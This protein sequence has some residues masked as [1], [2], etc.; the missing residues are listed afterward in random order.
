[1]PE[2]P[3]CAIYT[4]KSTSEGLDQEFNTLHAQRE[5]CER[6]IQAKAHEGWQILPDQYDDG[7]FTGANIERPAFQHLLADIDAG[8]IDLVIVYKVDR[9]SR[10]LLDFAQVMDRFNRAGV[11]FVSVTQNFSTADA[12]GRLTLNMLMSFAEFEREMIAE[13]TR[14]KIA[15]SRRKGIW[16]GGPVPLGYDVIDKKL[17]VNPVETPMVREIFELYVE[18]RSARTVARILNERGRTTKHHRAKNGNARGGGE[19]AKNSVLRVVCNPILAGY[20]PYRDE[21]HDGEHEAVIATDLFARVQT[22]LETRQK[23]RSKGVRNPAYILRGVLYCGCGG[24]CTPASARS[25]GKEYRYYRCVTRNR[26]GNEACTARPLPADAIE[27]F[28]IDRILEE[29]SSPGLAREVEVELLARIEGLRKTHQ[30]HIKVL[31]PRIKGL[32]VQGRRLAEQSGESE[33]AARQL[34]EDRI[35][36]IGRELDE[37]QKQVVDAKRQIAVL[38]QAEV[39]GKWVAATLQDFDRIWDVMSLA[40]KGRL[41]RAIVSK[42]VVDDARGSVV[43]ELVDLGAELSGAGGDREVGT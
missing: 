2:N 10:S 4:R 7:G 3:R 6:Y 33:G 24:A 8:R 15:A 20:M 28:V 35:T 29:A 31:R 25:R 22:I 18:H 38:D 23:C 34:I 12:M 27:G 32:K 36:D 39:D 43:V 14:D 13:R 1:M 17:V 5:A 16:T 11:A 26:H 21:L 9:L 19:Y 40:N 42:V 41:V 30:Q 37:A